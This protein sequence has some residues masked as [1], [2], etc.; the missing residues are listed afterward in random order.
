MVGR[1]VERR[2]VVVLGLHVGSRGHGVA[3][4]DEDVLDL[5]D[6]LADEV[7]GAHVGTAPRQGHVHG[8]GLDA[9][10]ELVGRQLLAA[11]GE[12]ALD[13]L[14]H[15]V[16]ALAHEGP[17]LGGHGAHGAEHRREAALLARHGDAHGVQRLEVDRLGDLLPGLG[18]NAVELVDHRHVSPSRPVP[19]PKQKPPLADWAK[20][21]RNPRYHL[22]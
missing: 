16:G 7:L 5:V 17:L 10:G 15:L 21:G 18:R 14:A 3:E 8:V 2:E 4:G 9:G 22:D 20:D 1:G 6:D 11:L 19:R 12:G 13:L